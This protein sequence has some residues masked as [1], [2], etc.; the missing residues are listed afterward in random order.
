MAPSNSKWMIA[1][2][3]ELKS[4]FVKSSSSTISISWTSESLIEASI[5]SKSWLNSNFLNSSILSSVSD[6]SGNLVSSNDTSIGLSQLIV[7]NVLLIKASS[8]LFSSFSFNFLPETS[9]ICSYTF[10]TVE[11]WF[12]SLMAVFSPTPATPGILSELS[13][14]RPFISIICFG[15]KP[16]YFSAINS[17]V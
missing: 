7:A 16:L 6:W 2:F 13:P 4:I 11:N 12:N 5:W 15:D 3:N 17:G 8:L 1:V 10:S 9:S 14:I